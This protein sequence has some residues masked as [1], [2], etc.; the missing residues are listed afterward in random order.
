MKVNRNGRSET[1]EVTADGEGFCSQVGAL[2]LSNLCDR[3]GLTS[4][5]TEALGPDPPEAAEKRAAELLAEAGEQ[6]VAKH[7][8]ACLGSVAVS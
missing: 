4:A 1:V 8:Q 6:Q 5:L 3:L 7:R 2:L